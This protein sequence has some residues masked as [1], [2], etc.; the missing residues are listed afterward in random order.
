MERTVSPFVVDDRIQS[1]IENLAK[2]T[3]IGKRIKEAFAADLLTSDGQRLFLDVA[4][5]NKWLQEGKEDDVI[6][7][8]VDG[9]RGF[10]IFRDTFSKA[11][12]FFYCSVEGNHRIIAAICALLKCKPNSCGPIKAANPGDNHHFSG[13]YAGIDSDDPLVEEFDLE[14]GESCS[15]FNTVLQVDLLGSK[16]Q[17]TPDWPAELLLEKIQRRLSEI[18]AETKRNSSYRT[19]AAAITPLVGPL[20][21]EKNVSAKSSDGSFYMN[22]I[23]IEEGKKTK[24]EDSAFYFNDVLSGF[25]H[26]PSAI[27]KH[28][29][30][31]LSDITFKE[32][33]TDN[34]MRINDTRLSIDNAIISQDNKTLRRSITEIIG[35]ALASVLEVDEAKRRALLFVDNYYGNSA[36][37]PRID[38][39]KAQKEMLGVYFPGLFKYSSEESKILTLNIFIT[40]WFIAANVNNAKDLLTK[41]I[42]QMNTDM[43]SFGES[44]VKES[45]GKFC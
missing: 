40:E 7:S 45:L 35:T 25:V 14:D 24:K 43:A 12:S 39:T 19:T 13:D 1:L 4:K 22:G 15:T 5:E 18:V 21:P 32:T 28:L 20:M 16:K 6:V 8:E 3:T 38:M 36:V 29:Q 26:N 30:G 27:G 34:H 23:K 42:N 31:L 41:A 33:G 44:N 11:L 37:R 10:M 9:V 2:D 17:A